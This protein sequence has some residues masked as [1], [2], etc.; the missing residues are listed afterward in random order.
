MIKDIEEK[1]ARLSDS[2]ETLHSRLRETTKTISD[3]RELCKKTAPM[4]GELNARIKDS[5]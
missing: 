3:C 1:A 5:K 4:I 2:F